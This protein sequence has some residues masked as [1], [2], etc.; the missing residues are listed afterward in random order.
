M[1][2]F[3]SFLSITPCLNVSTRCHG[4]VAIWNNEFV[5]GKFIWENGNLIV[6]D[7]ETANEI[8]GSLNVRGEFGPMR[9]DDETKTIEFG[10]VE[11]YYDN[12]YTPYYQYYS[13]FINGEVAER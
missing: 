7:E 3:C 8:I 2:S 4:W 10:V 1:K 11:M 9:Y 12:T 5:E 13:N 6:D